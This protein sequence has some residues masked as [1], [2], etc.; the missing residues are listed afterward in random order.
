MKCLQ[1]SP[2]ARI[3]ASKRS[4][5]RRSCT[6]SQ[7]SQYSRFL[8]GRKIRTRDAPHREQPSESWNRRSHGLALRQNSYLAPRRAISVTGKKSVATCKLSKCSKPRRGER[9]TGP[10]TFVTVKCRSRS[11]EARGRKFP[12]SFWS[13]QTPP[14][15]RSVSNAVSSSSGCNVARAPSSQSPSH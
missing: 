4:R 13:F 1:F 8:R 9:S 14:V 11:K 3:K 5:R 6:A 2:A 7:V 10:R 12:V 15:S